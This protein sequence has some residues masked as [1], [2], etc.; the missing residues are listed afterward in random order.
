METITITK[1][2]INV[3]DLEPITLVKTV[4]FSPVADLASA[5]AVLANDEAALLAV[6]NSGLMDRARETARAEASNWH[7]YKLDEQGEPTKEINGTFDGTLLEGE[8]E[9]KFSSLVLT[10]AKTMFGF[11]KG[12]GK[13]AKRD[14]KDNA[15]KF[16]QSNP[17]ILAA[18][19]G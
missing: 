6:V 7:T 17:A 12:A 16:I 18:L 15:R 13:D 8:A 2:G 3:V 19:K 14:A 5:L 11:G 9:E 4:E 10:F 1:S